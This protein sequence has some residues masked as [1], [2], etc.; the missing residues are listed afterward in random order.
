MGFQRKVY[1]LLSV[2]LLLTA[3][4]AGFCAYSEVLNSNSK[5]NPEIFFLCLPLSIVLFGALYIKRHD[6]P[7]NFYLLGAFPIVE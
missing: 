2:Q 7:A 6:V 5:N 1:S 3:I 4:V